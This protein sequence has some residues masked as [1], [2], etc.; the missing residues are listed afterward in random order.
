MRFLGKTKIQKNSRKS[1][2]WFWKEMRG[3]AWHNVKDE[4]ISWI[5]NHMKAMYK[6]I[7]EKLWGIWNEGIR[8]QYIAEWS[9][10]EAV[11]S[12][13]E[14]FRL[15]LALENRSVLKQFTKDFSLDNAIEL[16]WLVTASKLQP[17]WYPNKLETPPICLR[18]LHT[19]I[20][21]LYMVS[22]YHHFK[23]II[24]FHVFPRTWSS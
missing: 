17:L 6:G 8:I 5:L 22:N 2:W 15:Y 9:S 12:S 20:I 10:Y 11:S 1:S 14:A 24:L 21:Q 13:L 23:S 3:K 4:L 16:N 18:Q 19:T 7:H